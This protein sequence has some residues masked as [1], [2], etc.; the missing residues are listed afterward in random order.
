MEV[1][2]QVAWFRVQGHTLFTEGSR[3]AR[4]TPLA[5]STVCL[6]AFLAGWVSSWPICYLPSLLLAGAAAR[7][8]VNALIKQSALQCDGISAPVLGRSG[9]RRRHRRRHSAPAAFKSWWKPVFCSGSAEIG[10]LQASR[11]ERLGKS[12]TLRCCFTRYH[13][14]SNP[15]NKGE[16]PDPGEEPGWTEVRR[17][18]VSFPL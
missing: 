11:T 17:V 4:D 5:A 1:D 3:S 12:A 15:E 16:A 10:S 13:F 18:Q 2:R 14:E 7:C 8:S 9:P 6:S